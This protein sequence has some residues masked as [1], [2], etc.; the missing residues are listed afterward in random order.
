[1]HVDYAEEGRQKPQGYADSAQ[2][3]RR[4][5][6]NARCHA[7]EGALGEGEGY[8]EKLLASEHRKRLAA[9]GGRFGGRL[10]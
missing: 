1:M 5:L 7:S 10:R 2:R 4:L 8:L 6:S 3:Y 9:G